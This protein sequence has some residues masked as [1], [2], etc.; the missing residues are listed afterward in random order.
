MGLSLALLLSDQAH[1]HGIRRV[2]NE[3]IKTVLE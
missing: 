1:F 3:Y 2:S